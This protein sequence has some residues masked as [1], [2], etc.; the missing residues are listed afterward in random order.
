MEPKKK[1]A[2]NR[3]LKKKKTIKRKSEEKG[4]TEKRETPQKLCEGNETNRK[5]QRKQFVAQNRF[6]EF[7]SVELTL[8]SCA[9]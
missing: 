6:R 8:K 7:V 3:S 1:E 2:S 4:E 5:R 9:L